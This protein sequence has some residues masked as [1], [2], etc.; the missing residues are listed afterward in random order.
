MNLFLGASTIKGLDMAELSSCV[1]SCEAL[2]ELT[3]YTSTDP[4]ATGILVII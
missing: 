3:F 1:K 4:E 2:E